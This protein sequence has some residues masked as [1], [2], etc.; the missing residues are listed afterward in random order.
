ML[1]RMLAGRVGRRSGPAQDGA[2]HPPVAELADCG[3]LHDLRRR[4][5]DGIAARLHTRRTLIF[6]S[7]DGGTTYRAMWSG[8]ETRPIPNLMLP[9]H[10]RLARWLRVNAVPLR[11]D[12][13]AELDSWWS[14][15][16]RDLLAETGATL[17][18]P[19][20]ASGRLMAFACVAADGQTSVD[21]GS[22]LELEVFARHAAARWAELDQASRAEQA[23]RA[24]HRSHQLSVSGQLAAT[25]SHEVRN[26]LAAIRSLV[27]FVRD[28]DPEVSERNRLLDGVVEEVDRIEH[29]LARHLDLSRPHAHAPVEP[30][31]IDAGDLA[32]DVVAFV[33]PYATRRRIVV[34]FRAADVPLRVRVD[35]AELRQVFLNVLLNAY[36]ACAGGGHVTLSAGPR[37]AQGAPR[38]AEFTVTD[39]GQGLAPG[40]EARVFEPFFTTRPDGT[41]LGLSFCRDA[42]E[43]CGGSIALSSKPGCGTR[44]VITIPLIS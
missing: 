33:G 14:A 26:P 42:M 39:D 28:A 1:L 18:L 22:M 27:Q 44:V 6:E 24:L 9:G 21:D 3:A 43:R 34:E 37:E 7:G 13:G 5:G 40:D 25:V 8:D 41:G 10:G 32:G 35:P 4:V 2:G 16:E 29:T 31:E 17:C 20:V 19:F 38:V 30:V 23:A 36:Q 15:G 11:V 12:P